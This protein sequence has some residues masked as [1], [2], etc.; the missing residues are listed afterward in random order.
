[1]STARSNAN[2][3]A[4]L[5]SD[6][7]TGATFPPAGDEARSA[8]IAIQIAQPAGANGR[9]RFIPITRF[10]LIDRLTDPGAWPRGQAAH[11]RRFFRY[12]DYWRQQQYSARL[13]TL[14]QAYE[15]FSPD[16]D[17]LVTRSYAE[18]ERAALQ[19]RVV[20]GVQHLLT[21][22]NYTRIDPRQ[23]ELILTR[24]THYGLDLHV[25]LD[26]FEELLVYYRGESTRKDQRRTLR[27]FLRKQEFE[28]PI[29]RRLFVLFK[30]K[31]EAQRTEEVMRERMIPRRQALK[32]V[33]RMRSLLAPEIKDDG[34]YMKLF[35]NM[36]R[37]DI[38]M[39]FPNTRVRFR[40]FDKLK[41]GITSGAGLGM[42]AFSAA[43]KVALVGTNPV[44]AAGAVFGLG[45]IAFRQCMK[46]L[47]QRQRYMVVMAQNLYFHAMGDNRGVLVKLAS[48]AAEED[49]KEEILLYSVLA[50]SRVNRSELAAVD[51]AIEGYMLE[52]F[53]IKVDFEIEDALKRLLGDGL[54]AE[55][56]DGTLRTMPPDAA[57]SH[58]DRKWDAFL[59]ELSD[60][61]GGEG[62]EMLDGTSVPA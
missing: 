47:N 30:L 33:R 49:V 55:E 35:K 9:E 17:L 48:R 44:A 26:A 62:T 45:G 54:V 39:I 10:A 12:L 1:M 56:P 28:V 16:S 7:W 13:L 60:M 5:A 21:Q 31:S 15:P 3:T 4:A 25:D 6:E 34:I 11:A 32:A 42:G 19:R 37:S 14:E 41:L 53:G 18:H 23:V 8:G 52:A 43:G 50:K 59:D 22:A 27:K 38:E 24:E 46:F 20:S 40:L 2:G 36:P 51:Q 58:V 29:F 57:A 61:G